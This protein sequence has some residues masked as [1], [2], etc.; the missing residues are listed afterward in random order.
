MPAWLKKTLQF[1]IPLV[2][3]VVILYFVFSGQ[4]IDGIRDTL[5]NAHYGWIIASSAAALISHWLRA[6]RWAMLMGPLGEHPATALTFHAVMFGYLAN[7]AFPRMGEVTRCG[8]IARH[9]KLP[10]NGII[11]TVIIERAIDFMLLLVITAAT[12]L[13]NFGLLKGPM[14]KTLDRLAAFQPLGIS[15]YYW[16]FAG[17]AGALL[18]L[19]Y[20][21]R[22][23]A[24]LDHPLLIKIKGFARGILAGLKSITA[25]QKPVLF[26][27]YS[28][29]IWVCYYLMTYLCV[30]AFD[31]TSMLNPNEGL[32]ILVS[33]SFGMV[34]PVQGGIGAYHAVISKLLEVLPGRSISAADALSFATLTHAAQTLLILVVGLLSML[35]LFLK[36]RTHGIQ[37]LS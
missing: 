8:A 34:A 9:T 29:G 15:W 20:Y 21:R 18:L 7:L 28:I 1:T 27:V 16:I 10:V 31:T 22:R 13:L 23:L 6:K 12:V 2:L 32:L 14:F 33:G 25:L 19:W 4:D 37:K 11:G 5:A 36:K 3:G 24:H 30:F 35:W 17:L 26:W